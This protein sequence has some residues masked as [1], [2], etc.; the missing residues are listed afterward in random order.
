M[1]MYSLTSPYNSQRKK[2][3]NKTLRDRNRRAAACQPSVAA[4]AVAA[5]AATH[6]RQQ[7]SSHPDLYQPAPA[8]A[9]LRPLSPY[10]RPARPASPDT[11]A[12]GATARA[13][14]APAPVVAP[15]NSSTSSS[16]SSSFALP[17]SARVALEELRVSLDPRLVMHPTGHAMLPA[18]AAAGIRARVGG[19]GKSGEEQHSLLRWRTVLFFRRRRRGAAAGPRRR[20]AAA[21]RGGA[22][23]SAASQPYGDEEDVDGEEDDNEA[24]DFDEEQVPFVL[25]CLTAADV[26]RAVDK[27]EESRRG[28]ERRTDFDPGAGLE[29]LVRD[30]ASAH[31]GCTLGVAVEGLEAHCVSRERSAAA[32][33]ASRSS[34]SSA[35]AAAAAAPCF[36]ARRYDARLL[37]ASAAVRHPALRLALLPDAAAAAEHL[38]GL[39]RALAEQPLRAASAASAVSA[40]CGGGSGGGS[41]VSSS[42]QQQQQLLR[43]HGGGRRGDTQAAREALLLLEAGSAG[44][45]GGNGNGGGQQQLPAASVALARALARIPGVGPAAAIAVASEH[46]SFGALMR[47]VEGGGG[48]AGSGV[49]GRGGAAASAGPAALLAELRTSARGAAAG[50]G[51][52]VGPAAARRVVAMLR[53][54]DGGAAADW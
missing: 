52:R 21:R 53:A 45:G 11:F 42:R 31:P 20:A 14:P 43:T 1:S 32:A 49:G 33:S 37:A 41:G 19:G 4:A 7:H 48:G 38:V 12:A 13:A 27:A 17:S 40:S 51:P 15:N 39:A 5:A 3:Q 54:V 46:G 30:A 35:A 2:I 22:A 26:V 44:R 29:R 16:S 34:N 36:V 18:L 10:N 25:A 23:A 47:F 50:S 24:G 6:D 8:P 28:G 9:Q